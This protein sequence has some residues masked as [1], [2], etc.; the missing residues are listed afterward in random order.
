MPLTLRSRGG[1]IGAIDGVE[2]LATGD[3][4]LLLLWLVGEITRFFRAAG[5]AE[6]MLSRCFFLLCCCWWSAGLLFLGERGGL[7][8]GLNDCPGTFSAERMRSIFLCKLSI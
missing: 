4:L 1:G 5:R 6:A 3:L 2:G 7:I 8:G